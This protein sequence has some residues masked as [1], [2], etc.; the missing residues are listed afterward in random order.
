[1]AKYRH[2]GSI[3]L[4]EPEPESNNWWVWVV[5]VFF[6]LAMLGQCSGG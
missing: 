1:M 3:D 4:F 5:G 2:R 6:L